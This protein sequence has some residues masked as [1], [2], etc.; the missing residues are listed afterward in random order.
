V[1]TIASRRSWWLAIALVI[2]TVFAGCAADNAPPRLPDDPASAPAQARPPRIVASDQVKGR[3]WDLTIDSPAVGR[4]VK[5]RL[6]LPIRSEKAKTRRW[7]VL[8]LLHGCCDTYEA[9]TRSTDIEKRTRDLDVLVVMPDGGPAGFYSNWR[10]G[11]AW[12]AFHL[13][14]LGSLLTEKYRASDQR[15]IAG[16]SMGGLGALGYAAR[17]PGMFRVAASFSGIVHTR[18][19]GDHEAGYLNLLSSQGEDPRALWGDPDSD[20]EI[21]KAHNPYDLAPRLAGTKLFVSAGNGQPGPLDRDQTTSD[22]IE[23]SIGQENEAFVERL[24]K[25]RLDAQVELYGPGTHN[26]VYWQRELDHAWPLI[27]EGL[28]L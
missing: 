4:Q 26:W 19:S 17:N 27:T 5:V 1:A 14:E 9:W 16:L 20:E 15:A 11:P 7:P 13:T 3:M 23:I 2:F 21:W 25:L 8:Y 24:R 12:E 28:G 6:L 10:S 18:L 22:E